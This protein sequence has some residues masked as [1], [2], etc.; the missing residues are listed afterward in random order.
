MELSK[1]G[2]L[3][4]LW[5]AGLDEQ[6]WA[7]PPLER[8]RLTEPFQ[9]KADAS[10]KQP[11][12]KRTPAVLQATPSAPEF[13]ALVTAQVPAPEVNPQCRVQEPSRASRARTEQ[14]PGPQMRTGLVT[15]R[16]H[17][18]APL[19]KPTPVFVQGSSEVDLS[20]CDPVLAATREEQ[21]PDHD[22]SQPPR[23]LTPPR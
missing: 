15:L 8:V 7:D 18:P 6:A 13:V 14:T 3:I 1:L 20:K 9:P 2:V 10:S 19:G 16:W 5:L 17:L 11:E 4:P 12:R 22:Q 23:A 21:S